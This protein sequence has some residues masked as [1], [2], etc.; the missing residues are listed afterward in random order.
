MDHSCQMNLEMRA[1]IPFKI[2]GGM[3]VHFGASVKPSKLKV[4]RLVCRLKKTSPH[5]WQNKCRKEEPTVNL[6]V[7]RPAPQLLGASPVYT[8]WQ[9]DSMVGVGFFC[10]VGDFWVVVCLVFLKVVIK[11]FRG[12]FFSLTPILFLSRSSAH[13][14][15]QTP[16][17]SVGV[18]VGLY[19]WWWQLNSVVRSRVGW[20]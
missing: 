14:A 6:H 13:K 16:I 8:S 18:D 4:M 9:P 17:A 7:Y 1:F 20:Q 10:L 2:Q 15:E 11:L 12:N 3:K 19:A 5:R